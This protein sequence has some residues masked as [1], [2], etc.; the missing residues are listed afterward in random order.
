VIK[1]KV[2]S[3][4]TNLHQQKPPGPFGYLWTTATNAQAPMQAESC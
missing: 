3:L 1:D 2:L 4:K